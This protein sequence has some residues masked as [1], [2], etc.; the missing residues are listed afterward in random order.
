MTNTAIIPQQPAALEAR[1]RTMS[2]LVAALQ[3]DPQ[4]TRIDTVRLAE[5]FIIELGL[6]SESGSLPEREIA[7]TVGDYIS[8]VS[9]SEETAVERAMLRG[10]Y[11]T[12]SLNKALSKALQ[13]RLYKLALSGAWSESDGFNY[14]RDQVIDVIREEQGMGY[15]NAA[16]WAD[17]L[18]VIIWLYTVGNRDR[19]GLTQTPA[20]AEEF[21]HLYFTRLARIASRVWKLIIRA[22]Q[23]TELP[24][25][26]WAQL[27]RMA[28]SPDFNPQ[29]PGDTRPAAELYRAIARIHDAL[30]MVLN[31]KYSTADIEAGARAALPPINPIE[32]PEDIELDPAQKALLKRAVGA[33]KI[34]FPEEKPALEDSYAVQYKL[35]QLGVCPGCGG[36]LKAQI[37]EGDWYCI[38]CQDVIVAPATWADY[39]ERRYQTTMGTMSKWEV[40]TRPQ[41]EAWNP[42]IVEV[43]HR[44]KVYIFN[45]VEKAYREEPEVDGEI[46]QDTSGEK[47]LHD[48]LVE[49]MATYEEKHGLAPRYI[50]V[51]RNE[52]DQAKKLDIE[53][54]TIQPS[55]TVSY[56]Y[57]YHLYYEEQEAGSGD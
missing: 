24:Q 44:F 10:L 54:V 14:I 34:I 40:S 18:Q 31:P 21:I 52:W 2:D 41:M 28:K 46:W 17:A 12:R 3:H 16:R 47:S 38:H 43:D 22:T 23:N 51:N 5:D 53:N 20:L 15:D 39:W 7:E 37:P 26:S 42:E 55:K 49:G 1:G 50:Y 56:R 36:H 57:Q 45:T 25:I 13:Q 19:Y 33:G 32:W 8:R 6:A 35:L 4:V 29:N 9:K 11:S 27:I 48:K 30:G